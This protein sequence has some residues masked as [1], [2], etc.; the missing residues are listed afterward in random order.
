MRRQGNWIF[1]VFAILII[2]GGSIIY[3]RYPRTLVIGI[4][5]RVPIDI[6][7]QLTR[8]A[9]IDRLEY[10]SKNNS[11]IKY[12]LIV[13]N[14]SNYI[15]LKNAFVDLIEKNAEVIIGPMNSS[16]TEKIIDLANE[17]KRL[18][19]LQGITNPE[20][21]RSSK[22][23]ISTGI[24]DE[25]QVEA[26]VSYIKAKNYKKIVIIKSEMNPVY[27]DYIAFS[28]RDKLPEKE[29]KIFSFNMDKKEE[30]INSI[31][32]GLNNPEI[33]V[34][35]TSLEESSFVINRLNYKKG[36]FLLT[37]W[38]ASE[39]L[40]ST[41][42]TKSNG[43]LMISFCPYKVLKKSPYKGYFY[44]AAFES[45]GLLNKLFSEGKLKNPEKVFSNYAYKG[46]YLTLRFKGGLLI[47]DIYIWRVKNLK[48]EDYLKYSIESGRLMTVGN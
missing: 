30:N 6:D 44:L 9:I 8:E 26:M 29:T 48:I 7:T 27:S 15:E 35:I 13:R 20:I 47:N 33:I 2:L 45:I 40:V 34:C 5:E 10:L 37:D 46:K 36:E 3:L 16:D 32:E 31:N 14:Y 41:L 24:P 38:A 11:S 21:L 18:I 25:F 23:F 19:F 22:Y 4:L 28:L 12:K 39:E 43:V 17:Y 1:Y 42:G